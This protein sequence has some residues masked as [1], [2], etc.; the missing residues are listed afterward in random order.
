MAP[1]FSI[2]RKTLA[3]LA[4]ALLPLAN[5]ASLVSSAHILPRD[6]P[7]KIPTCAP[8][9]DK[10]FQPAFDF[11]TDSCYNVPAIGADGTLNPGLNNCYTSNT[12]G[13]RDASFLDNSNAY[14]RSRCNNGWC[15]YMYGYYFQ[16]DVALQ[17]VCGVGAGHRH[18]WEH[19][20]VWTQGD[21]VKYVGT[22]AHGKYHLKEA[23]DVRWDG[24]HPK[25]VYHKDGASTHAM[26]FASEGDDNPVENDKHAWFYAD[27]I[28]YNG[29]PNDGLRDKLMGAN[30][31][32]ATMDIKDG[33]FPA[34]I[35][36]AKDG[37][38]DIALDVNRDDGSPGEPVGC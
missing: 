32:S 4:A 14:S 33:R 17:H 29:F 2:N 15:I 30:F 9:N 35:D 38:G 12:S 8:D 24:T 18:D 13:C 34:A 37:H 1:S 10:K 25:I 22:S 31:G 23:K 19:V 26:R 5:A 27:L 16:K 36:S 6:N 28:S 11:D 20:V 21:Q 3:V 7:A